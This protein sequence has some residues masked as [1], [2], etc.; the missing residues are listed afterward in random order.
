MARSNRDVSSPLKPDILRRDLEQLRSLQLR[1][2]GMTLSI[3]VI[4]FFHN[5]FCQAT[6]EYFGIPFLSNI[7]NSCGGTG[8]LT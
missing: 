5:G 3:G 8:R 1:A 4:R 6:T 7:A 2:A